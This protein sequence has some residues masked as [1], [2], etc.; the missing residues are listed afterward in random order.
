ML[1]MTSD[2]PVTMEE[3]QL[4]GKE[5]RSRIV[6]ASHSIIVS[7]ISEVSLGCDVHEGDGGSDRGI[8]Q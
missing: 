6:L 5:T 8:W 4:D 1:L 3:H 7:L 2:L